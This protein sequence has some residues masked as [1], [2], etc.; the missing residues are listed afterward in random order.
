MMRKNEDKDFF[1]VNCQNYQNE[2]YIEA[3]C[4]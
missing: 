4:E 3:G 1:K 2:L